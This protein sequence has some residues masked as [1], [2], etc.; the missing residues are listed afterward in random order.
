VN[1]SESHYSL[2]GHRFLMLAS[3]RMLE[4]EINI[5]INIG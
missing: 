2:I 3:R 4:A 1:W 5:N